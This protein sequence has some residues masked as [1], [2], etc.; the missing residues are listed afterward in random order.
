M[1]TD[2]PL[3]FRSANNFLKL[4]LL[5]SDWVSFVPIWRRMLVIVDGREAR[6]WG[7]LQRM[8]VVVAPG[9]QCVI[10]LMN[11]TCFVIESPM[12]TMVGIMRGRGMDTGG[13]ERGELRSSVRGK[14]SA[15]DGR[16]G[17]RGCGGEETVCE[18]VLTSDR[19]GG[20]VDGMGFISSC[21][22]GAGGSAL[23][24][25]DGWGEW[26]S[27]ERLTTAVRR[28]WRRMETG[29][30][31]IGELIGQRTFGGVDFGAR[32]L[33]LVE[34][35][36]EGGQ[37][38][39]PRPRPMCLHDGTGVEQAGGGDMGNGATAFRRL[40]PA[41]GGHMGRVSSSPRSLWTKW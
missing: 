35:M 10:A 21:T 4:D 28:S 22:G 26:S 13:T 18:D 32:D 39:F 20:T 36:G 11:W 16:V 24:A 2:K 3:L 30:G 27:P 41:V 1:W 7:S 37:R 8:S 15:V 38:G 33:F 12:M 31:S 19:G 25:V 9:K 40:G 23:L 5:S 17:T 14:G 29:P 6:I 34:G